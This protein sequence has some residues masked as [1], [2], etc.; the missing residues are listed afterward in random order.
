MEKKMVKKKTKSSLIRKIYLYLFSIIGL[1]LM[2]IGSVGIIDLALK[3]WIFTD[4]E[5]EEKM[6][7][8]QPPQPWS[9]EK[10]NSL[11]ENSELT[12]EEREA[13]SRWLQDYEAW[14]ERQKNYDP[15]KSRRQR[16]IANNIA[17]LLVGLPLYLFHWRLI[18]R[19]TD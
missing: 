14:E 8:L 19:E 7:A 9:L 18:R 2:V 13:V 16:Q 11:A 1:V 10:T 6:Y 5:S 17:M 3:A 4:A 15:L 12:A